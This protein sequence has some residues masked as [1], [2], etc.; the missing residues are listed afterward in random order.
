MVCNEGDEGDHCVF[1]DDTVVVDDGMLTVTGYSHDTWL[2]HSISMVT[3]TC[4]GDAEPV[5][6]EQFVNHPVVYKIH[7]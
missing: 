7:S 5:A 6:T 2:C 4:T 1:T 3:V